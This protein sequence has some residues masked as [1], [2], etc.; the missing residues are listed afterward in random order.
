[1]D[2]EPGAALYLLGLVMAGPMGRSCAH[3]NTSFLLFGLTAMR[4]RLDSI[5]SGFMSSRAMVIF[6]WSASALEPRRNNTLGGV[7]NDD[8]DDDDDDDGRLIDNAA[9]HA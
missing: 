4:K 3:P 2:P 1:M 7:P 8:D 5:P 9:L 6:I